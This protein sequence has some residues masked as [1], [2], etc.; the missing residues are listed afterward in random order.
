MMTLMN[1]NIPATPRLAISRYSPK[2]SRMGHD[3]RLWIWLPLATIFS[4]SVVMR[5]T[6]MI[7]RR[8]YSEG[9]QCVREGEEYMISKKRE[10]V[11]LV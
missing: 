6:T 4:T 5:L 2:M 11:R 1:P 8:G 10:K 7:I 9:R 3:H